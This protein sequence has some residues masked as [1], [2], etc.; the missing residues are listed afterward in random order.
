MTLA[1]RR[2]LVRWPSVLG[3]FRRLPGGKSTLRLVFVHDATLPWRHE[4][5][6]QVVSRGN[7]NCK[8]VSRADRE[9]VPVPAGAFELSAQQPLEPSFSMALNAISS[10][11]ELEEAK[12]RE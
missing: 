3:S 5:K 4:G 7:P 6:T 2:R 12:Q 10:I 11:A 8:I 9:V 1:I